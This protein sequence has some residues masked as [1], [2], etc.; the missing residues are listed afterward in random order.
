MVA[1]KQDKYEVPKIQQVKSAKSQKSKQS[2]DEEDDDDDDSV[3]LKIS[4]KLSKG[5][6]TIYEEEMGVR[7]KKD[8]N[9]VKRDY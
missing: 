8:R 6:N 3:S 9:I 2:S 7:K 5:G 1:A 4:S